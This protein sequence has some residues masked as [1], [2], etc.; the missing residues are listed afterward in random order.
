M[1]QDQINEILDTLQG[2]LKAINLGFNFYDDVY[3][4]HNNDVQD[5]CADIERILKANGREVK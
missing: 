4:I 5:T 2:A 3:G 1:D